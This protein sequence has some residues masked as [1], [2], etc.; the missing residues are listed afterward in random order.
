M[1]VEQSNY[2]IA[3]ILL[4]FTAQIHNGTATLLQEKC[5]NPDFTTT[6]RSILLT[7][8]H[9]FEGKSLAVQ[10]AHVKHTSVHRGPEFDSQLHLQKIVIYFTTNLSYFSQTTAISTGCAICFGHFSI[11]LDY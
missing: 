11:V 7:D 10:S 6:D 9:T 3:K 1:N 2:T 4:S 5:H 8:S